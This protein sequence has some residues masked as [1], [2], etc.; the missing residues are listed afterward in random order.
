MEAPAIPENEELRLKALA[1]A[2]L[3]ATPAESD[4]DR[5]TQ[6]A[7]EHFGVPIALFSLVDRTRQWLKS[8]CG[9]D[10]SGSPRDISFCGHAILSDEPFV[11][12][13]ARSDARFADNPLVTGEPHIAFYAGMPIA[14]SD[15]FIIGT[16]CIIDRAPRSLSDKEVQRLGD[17]A[18]WLQLAIE[19][20]QLG[21]SE[22]EL[23]TELEAARR[24][25]L[26]C[27]MTQAW[28]RRGFSSLFSREMSK[29]AR[30]ATAVALLMLDIDHFKRINDTYGHP[31]GDDAIALL[32]RL[33]RENVRGHDV[34]ARMGGEEF[35]VIAPGAQREEAVLLGEK[36]RGA[37]ERHAILANGDRFTVSVGVGWFEPGGKL[38]DEAAMIENADRALYAAK[39]SGRNCVRVD[40]G[41]SS[42][43]TAAVQPA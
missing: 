23:I 42:E 19:N 13:D 3:L 43:T 29:A 11:V 33:L 17:F 22:V 20:R 18:R 40:L 28:N 4:F 10:A 25:S 41:A 15:G 34:V 12:P 14:S 24:E 7:A 8:R 16:L 39:H 36:L 27:P 35:A 6:T 32:A 1:E 26:I 38:P 2:Q 37:V 31:V 21:A 9:V 5:I 30:D